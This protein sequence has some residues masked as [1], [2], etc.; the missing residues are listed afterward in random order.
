MMAEV[1]SFRRLAWRLLGEIGRQPRQTVDAIGQGM[2]IHKTLSRYRSDLHS[3]GHLADR[4]DLFDRLQ[5]RWVICG[6]IDRCR[7]ADGSE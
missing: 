4:L 5:Q 6:V 1:L 2:L 7:S 3:F